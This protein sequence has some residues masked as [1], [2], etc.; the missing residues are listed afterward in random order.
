MLMEPRTE[1]PWPSL[2]AE[3]AAPYATGVGSRTSGWLDEVVGIA[4]VRDRQM[5]RLVGLLV[6]A[7]AADDLAEVTGGM[8]LHVWLQ[9]QVRCT[10]AEARDVLG[11]VEMLADMPATLAGLGDRWLSWSQVSAICRA[12]RRVRVGMRGELDRLVA[13]AMVAH[14]DWEPD[15]IVQDVWDWVDQH[16][17]SRLEQAEQAAERQRFLQL[18]PNLFGGGALYGELDTDRVRHGGRG[19]GRPARPARRGP[20]RPGRPGR[21]RRRARPARPASPR[22]GPRPRGRAGGP[23]GGPVRGPPRRHERYRAAR[24]PPA[25]AGHRRPRRA[26]RP[27]P[28]ARLAAAHP[29]RRTA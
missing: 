8:S 24:A 23:A 2:A 7:S 27:D 9:H 25:A 14:R 22:V 5:G 26:A 1:I 13:D 17:P 29:G 12:A 16:Q 3:T 19:A 28:H 20:R 15:A 11:A 6:A 4:E 10:H 18:S 21:G